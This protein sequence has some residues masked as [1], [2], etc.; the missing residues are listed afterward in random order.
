MNGMI[1]KT[2]FF[3]DSAVENSLFSSVFHFQQCYFSEIRRQMNETKK[4]HPE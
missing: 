1:Y 3:K 4:Y 2:K